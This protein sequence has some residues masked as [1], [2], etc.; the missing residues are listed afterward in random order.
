MFGYALF[1]AFVFLFVAH[2]VGWLATTIGLIVL[3]NVVNQFFLGS[4]K[5]LLTLPSGLLWL[6]I[7]LGT[8]AAT[9][10]GWAALSLYHP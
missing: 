9:A 7:G 2:A 3:F 10:W 4:P 1:L 5:E 8:M 6:L